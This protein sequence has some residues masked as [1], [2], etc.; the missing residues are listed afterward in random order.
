[1]A[2]DPK[3]PNARTALV[4]VRPEFGRWADTE[5]GLR[6]ILRDDPK[7]SPALTYLVMTLQA[8]GRAHESFKLNEKVLALEPLSP[9]HL[10]RRGLKLWILGYTAA[11]DL[12]IDR[13]LQLWP[14]HPAVWNARLMIFAFTGRADAALSLVNDVETRPAL[15]PQFF[16]NWRTSV[17]ALGSL[18]PKDIAAARES[19]LAAAPKNPSFAVWAMMALS[20]LGEVDAAFSVADGTLL[21]RGPLVGALTGGKGQ[22]DVN[23]QYWRRTMNLFTPATAAMR[24]DARFKTLCEG[25]GMMAYWRQRGIGP[26]AMYHL[27]FA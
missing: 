24:R 10:F 13:A 27:N 7:N 17:K 26:D 15:P 12:A 20:A 9:V 4:T 19:N 16:D 8:V 22:L 23:D 21:R 11:A 14:R 3:E 1:L 5:D 6:A 18:V 25:M 2:L